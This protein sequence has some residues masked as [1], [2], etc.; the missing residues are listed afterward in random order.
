MVVMWHSS[1]TIHAPGEAELYN[2]TRQRRLRVFATNGSATRETLWRDLL[3]GCVEEF[4]AA[5]PSV[6]S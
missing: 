5:N 1:A 6:T 3:F 4:E 2:T